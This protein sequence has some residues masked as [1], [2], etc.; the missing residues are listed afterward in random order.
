[1]KH[2]KEIHSYICVKDNTPKII[3][4]NSQTEILRDQTNKSIKELGNKYYQIKYILE[5]INIHRDAL[6]NIG[7]RLEE[8]YKK[9]KYIKPLKAKQRRMKDSLYCWYA[10]NFYNE[11]IQPNSFFIEKIKH[12]N[13]QNCLSQCTNEFTENITNIDNNN[14]I[15][16]Y[17][18]EP[19]KNE[20]FY[21]FNHFTNIYLI[22]EQ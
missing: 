17:E 21:I 3:N 2:N 4:G 19:Q 12:Y 15:L 11:M 8:E 20:I 13:S 5:R 7:K 14:Q 18:N 6:Y 22:T 10:E 1:M 9:L 16:I